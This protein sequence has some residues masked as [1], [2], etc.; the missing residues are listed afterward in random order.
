MN[1]PKGCKVTLVE[2]PNAVG[3]TPKM[4]EDATSSASRVTQ[5]KAVVG[6]RRRT[7]D[8]VLIGVGAVVTLVLAAAG[9]L[10]LWGHNFATDYVHK[11]LSSQNIYFPARAALQEEGRTDLVGYAEQQVTKGTQAQ[12]YASYIGGH[13]EGIADG[14]TYADLG[15]PERAAKAAVQTA[16]D[17]GE[18][19]AVVADLQAKAD[20][21]TNQ[22]NT[23]FKG[24]T[25]R[26]LLLST[27]A[28]STIGRIAGIAAIV[29]FV[30]A[31]V[32]LVLVML[33]FAHR[34]ELRTT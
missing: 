34:H 13:L 30:A 14:A 9:G 33:G 12:A 20:S 2:N 3:Q 5:Q 7:I 26:G 24:E 28:W 11:E 31:G 27:Y 15:A 17:K 6:V 8:T 32:M 19:A 16:T 29:A 23:L 10:L 25:L 1:H 18:S 22:R 21:I 4:K